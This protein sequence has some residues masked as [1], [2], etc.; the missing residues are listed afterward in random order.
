MVSQSHSLYPTYVVAKDFVW[1]ACRGGRECGTHASGLC[2]SAEA[3][4][5]APCACLPCSYPPPGP[6]FPPPLPQGT[7]LLPI[8]HP[9]PHH[10]GESVLTAHARSLENPYQAELAFICCVQLCILSSCQSLYMYSYGMRSHTCMK[11]GVWCG[12][13]HEAFRCSIV[14]VNP[15]C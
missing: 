14:P 1:Y 9:I 2:G 10:V 11:S 7:P 12:P 15:A 13:V 3:P 8:P 5:V 6:R 4:P